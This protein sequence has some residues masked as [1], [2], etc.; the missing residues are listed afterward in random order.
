MQS[1][2]YANLLC[3]VSYYWLMMVF[4][5]SLT[6]SCQSLMTSK[7]FLSSRLTPPD[8]RCGRCFGT[9]NV[10]LLVT[11]G[12]VGSIHCHFLQLTFFQG[13]LPFG[14]LFGRQL[15]AQQVSL[16]PTQIIP[17]R[18]GK[19]AVDEILMRL[20]DHM[21]NFCLGP[22]DDTSIR[23]VCPRHKRHKAGGP[24]TN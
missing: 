19:K 23:D 12:P 3:P 16:S 1:L 4:I 14:S 18:L 15:V 10:G 11:S 13:A 17:E 6:H 5:G 24:L 9:N 7:K 20:R 8:L 21:K 22:G 2:I